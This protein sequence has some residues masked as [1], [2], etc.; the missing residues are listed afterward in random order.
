MFSVHPIQRVEWQ[1][2]P[3]SDGSPNLPAFDG[4]GRTQQGTD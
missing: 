4:K 2:E 1:V 3:G